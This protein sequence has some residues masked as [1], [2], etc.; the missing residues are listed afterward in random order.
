MAK[1]TKLEPHQQQAIDKLKRNNAV[2]VY[3]GLGSGKTLTALS[4]A[5]QLETPLSVI[6]PASLRSNFA[7]EKTKHNL[8]VSVDYS[9]YSRPQ[10]AS[11]N[12]VAFDEAHRMGR[13]DSQLSHL[14]DQIYAKKKMF[15]TGTPLRN[16]PAELIPILRGLGVDISRDP[17]KF[18][19]QFLEKKI[20]QPSFIGRLKG[21]EPGIEY[22]P[23]NLNKLT[24]MVL[25]KVDYHA[26]AEKGYPTKIELEEI[27]PMSKEQ[28]DTYNM[29]SAGQPTIAY[30]IKYGIP[31]GRK[32][33]RFINAFLTQTR[34]V[35]NFPEKYNAVSGQSPKLKKIVSDIQKASKEK[36]YRGVTYSNFL[37]AGISPLAAELEKAK[38]PYA[39]F[40]GKSSEK[41]RIKAVQDYNTGKIK[42]L[43]IS[44]AGSEGLDL[45]KTHMLQ[46]MEPH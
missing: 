28:R 27:V 29:L 35:S 9:T 33:A 44:G 6:G 13:L 22:H 8:A 11:H 31:A 21:V 38:I 15:L 2:L 12:L 26:S 36:G 40:T 3:H 16:E 45:K 41:E 5:K 4:A 25:D 1:T 7:K 30:K 20:I 10:P 46:I 24:G 17:K 39:I 43:L 19:E 32:D 37:E 23:K 42:Q 18:N 14:P 34:Q